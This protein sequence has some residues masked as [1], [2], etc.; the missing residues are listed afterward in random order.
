MLDLR[1]INTITH[2]SNIYLSYY[3]FIYK[4][5]NI[6]L[7]A[8]GVEWLLNGKVLLDMFIHAIHRS[9]VFLYSFQHYTY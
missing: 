1:I 4:Y 7:I 8:M 5:N 3:L 2:K 6:Y 9:L